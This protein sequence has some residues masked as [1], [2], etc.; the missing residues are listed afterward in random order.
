LG[1]AIKF[2]ND[3]KPEKEA[4]YIVAG[5]YPDI[6]NDLKYGRISYYPFASRNELFGAKPSNY[7]VGKTEFP[8]L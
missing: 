1:G 5:N 3:K 6:G 8:I 7:P 4:G 2:W